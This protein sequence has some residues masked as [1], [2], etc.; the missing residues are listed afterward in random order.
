MV[1]DDQLIRLRDAFDN[2][3]AK[4]VSAPV[5]SPQKYESLLRAFYA[6]DKENI[7]QG[8][9]LRSETASA[10][11]GRG[12]AASAAG[13]GTLDA[14][15]ALLAAV[16]ESDAQAIKVSCPGGVTMIGFTHTWP[17]YWTRS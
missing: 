7:P 9:V 3:L 1:C 11:P 8:D 2:E 5:F 6:L 16:K 15:A 13:N 12:R 14:G 17:C 10:V 4:L